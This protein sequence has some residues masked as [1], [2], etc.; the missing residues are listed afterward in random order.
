MVASWRV[1]PGQADGRG[2][3]PGWPQQV[4]PPALLPGHH[5][6][7]EHGGA[8]GAGEVTLQGLQGKMELY[9]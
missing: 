7:Q 1:C 8:K 4:L 6:S 2:V 3:A 5:V 9:W